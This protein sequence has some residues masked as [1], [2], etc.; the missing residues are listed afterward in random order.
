MNKIVFLS[1]L[2]EDSFAKN[3]FS[4]EIEIFLGVGV[5]PEKFSKK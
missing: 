2:K 3:P 1:I 5:L 4:N